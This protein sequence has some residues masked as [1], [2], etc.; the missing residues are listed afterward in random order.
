MEMKNFIPHVEITQMNPAWLCLEKAVGGDDT[1]F[2][3][4]DAN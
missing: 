2:K 4:L 1:D 3:W